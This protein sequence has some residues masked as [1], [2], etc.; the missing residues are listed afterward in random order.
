MAYVSSPS[1]R[2]E[3]DERNRALQGQEAGAVDGG[4]SVGGG[5][6]GAPQSFT[7]TP[8]V[9]GQKI[10][11]KNRQNPGSFDVT[12]NYQ[13]DLNESKVNLNRRQTEYAADLNR[14]ASNF[15]AD[16]SDAN[17]AAEGDSNSF[18]RIRAALNPQLQ[19]PKFDPG[20]TKYNVSDVNALNTSAGLQNAISKE[21]VAGG[22]QNYSR[23]MGALDTAIYQQSPQYRQ[24]ISKVS[25]G[26]QDF[27]RQADATKAQADSLFDQTRYKLEN[28]ATELKNRLAA[29]GEDMQRR[30]EQSKLREASENQA[31]TQAI[32][33]E[34]ANKLKGDKDK[35]NAFFSGVRG[36]SKEHA[37]LFDPINQLGNQL[38]G[39]SGNGYSADEAAQYNRIMELLGANQRVASEAGQYDEASYR[40]ALQ[41]AVNNV[42]RSVATKK[43]DTAKNN[44]L[45]DERAKQQSAG[46]NWQEERAKIAK[47]EA[48]DLAYLEQRKEERRRYAP[49]YGPQGY[50]ERELEI[51][52]RMGNR[53]G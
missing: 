42:G 52:N 24:A 2:D 35:Y 30:A 47:Q 16:A 15:Q 20:Q 19:K 46:A 48:D 1:Q 3:D 31:R 12:K 8:F 6:A 51:L 29:R 33:D 40:N 41:N 14:E 17:K 37:A 43:E 9:S 34:Y 45:Q 36:A 32:F 25:Q 53:R 44:A 22:A 49:G 5:I 23:G 26:Y 50:D 13:Q 21:A 4:Q 7:K 39:V 38:R 18:A 28:N 27:G 10:I 11:E